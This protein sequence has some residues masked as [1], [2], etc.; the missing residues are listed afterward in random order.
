MCRRTVVGKV[1]AAVNPDALLRDLDVLLGVD[2]PLALGGDP[3]TLSMVNRL[4]LRVFAGQAVVLGRSV[5]A[6]W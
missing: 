2:R 1:E 5:C 3:F 4:L 6:A